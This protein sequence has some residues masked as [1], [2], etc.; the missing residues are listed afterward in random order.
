MT[1]ET[2]VEFLRLVTFLC[3]TDLS[4]TSRVLGPD[5]I[6]SLALLTFGYSLRCRDIVNVFPRVE[7]ARDRQVI[8]DEEENPVEKLGPL[9]NSR[10]Y[11]TPLRKQSLLSLTLWD[12]SEMKL[13]TQ[14]MILLGT[15]ICF[16]FLT[17]IL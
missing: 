10:W 17:N 7:N 6:L 5:Q 3:Q 8:D 12:L 16:N 9:G 2:D 4:S 1:T 13:I 14:F 11:F 15:L